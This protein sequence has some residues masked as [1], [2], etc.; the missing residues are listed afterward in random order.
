[1]SK[2]FDFENDFHFSKR[3]N[4]T[5]DP[6]S[7]EVRPGAPRR[8]WAGK[9]GT[10]ASYVNTKT[11]SQNVV[12][13]AHYYPGG[14]LTARHIKEYMQKEG[15]GR[16]GEKSS[17]F[18]EDGRTIN[19]KVDLTEKRHFRLIISPENGEKLDMEKYVKEVMRRV[20]ASLGRKLDWVGAVHYDRDQ[21]HA[22]VVIRG[23]DLAGRE[24]LIS[25]EFIKEGMR[26]IARGVATENLGPP[27][28]LDIDR[29]MNNDIRAERFTLIDKRIINR[30]D[31]SF[32]SELRFRPT[33]TDGDKYGI[34]VTKD[35]VE[36]ARLEKLE[37]MNIGLARRVDHNEFRKAV[38][39]E[40]IYETR[41]V[42]LVSKTLEADLRNLG[43]RNDIVKNLF[44]DWG[45]EAKTITTATLTH[46][47]SGT[48]VARKADNMKELE[49][50]VYL[51][52]DSGNGQTFQVRGT[53]QLLKHAR[54]EKLY[55]Y[56]GW[57]GKDG[58]YIDEAGVMKNYISWQKQDGSPSIVSK[59]FFSGTII[60]VVGRTQKSP[61][62]IVLEDKEGKRYSWNGPG[63]WT[64]RLGDHAMFYNNNLV[65]FSKTIKHLNENQT[66]EQ[67]R[68]ARNA[69]TRADDSRKPRR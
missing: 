7:A 5:T 25:P 29:Q 56:R 11:Y 22:H 59:G 26:E 21:I 65:G 60:E 54:D 27:T 36:R 39:R 67:K 30:L 43:I 62:Y 51:L 31:F 55:Y 6:G 48:V 4:R 13:K 49:D 12:V 42:Y 37:S 10:F 63:Y 64:K 24:V 52:V 33:D 34:V 20:E 28:I 17:L 23:R 16:D 57:V 61:G 38:G 2:V 41:G 35:A 14:K 66:N 3:K 58:S 69:N 1:M 8:G 18:T 9:H 40:R 45:N 44:R 50:G 15:K 47:F 53:R 19:T 32:T 46:E 68:G